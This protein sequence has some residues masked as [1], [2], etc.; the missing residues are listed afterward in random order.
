MPANLTPDYLA[1]EREYKQAQT[2][3]E[4]IAALEN[5]LALVPKHKGTEKLQADL[6]RRLSQT[7]KESQKKGAAHST[8]FYLIE[9][10][11]AGQVAL[12]GP[13]NS[14]KS[15]LVRALT[16]AEPEV[17]D[18]P[19]TTR[20]PTPAMMRFEN[21]QIQL[22][23]LPPLA[24]EFTVP[25]LA[26]P[27]R[28]ATM[29][30]LVADPNDANV[31]DEIGFIEQTL[32]A[33]RVAP[34]GLLVANK[35]DLPGFEE[36]FAVLEE[37]FRPRYRCLALSAKAGKNLECFARAVFDSLHLVRVYTKPPGKKADLTTPYVLNRGQTVLDAAKLVH[38]AF[39][40]QLK[41][42]RLFHL[43]GSHDG[44]MV[45]RTHAVEDGDILEFHI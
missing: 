17:G 24:A 7:R 25:W 2:P 27:I 6:K 29:S 18:Y 35:A 37:L 40:E 19:F 22:V 20:F 16:H 36:A 21:V 33:W 12:I 23:D 11:G 26:H 42:A 13:P 4:R 44:M 1:A 5:M 3:G 15:Q 41:F 39:A 43:S 10:E 45:E 30:V 9:R 14:G 32:D 34:P 31:L 8:P 28:R 38:K